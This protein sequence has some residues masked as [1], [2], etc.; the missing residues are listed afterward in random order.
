LS[1]YLVTI[2][3]E[4]KKPGAWRRCGVLQSANRARLDKLSIEAH[5]ESQ[6][7]AQ[8]YFLLRQ[9]PF[10]P[11]AVLWSV[12]RGRPK[13]WRALLSRPGVLAEHLVKA[14]FPDSISYSCAEVEVVAD[15]MVAFLAGEDIRFSLD[16]ARLDLCSTFQ[17]KVL[18]AEYRIPRGSVSTYQRIARHLGNPN[19]ARAV[20]AALANNPFPIIIP[21]HRAIRS[22]GT[23][24]GYQGGLGMKRALLAMEGV[25]FDSKGRLLAG[26][27]FY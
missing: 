18:R 25:R 16:I 21:C 1:F 15:Q 11:V 22:D 4:P 20:G 9:T 7:A 27:I 3:Y 10:G 17:Q 5:T 12:H 13:I 14:A 2:E 8:P 26:E 23:L 19:G 24:S 6:I